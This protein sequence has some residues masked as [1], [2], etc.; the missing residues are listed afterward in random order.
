MSI[1]AYQLEI[2]Q[3]LAQLNERGIVPRGGDLSALWV[4]DLK[5][6]A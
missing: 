4:S 5:Q 3:A 6:L 1:K 2:R